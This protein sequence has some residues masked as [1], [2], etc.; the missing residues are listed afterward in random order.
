MLM[1]I[2]FVVEQHEDT[3]VAYPLGIRGGVVGEGETAAAALEDARCATEVYIEALGVGV[4][5]DQSP[6]AAFVSEQA[7]TVK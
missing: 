1:Q 7:V 2:K 6:V 5:E 4:I 3:F